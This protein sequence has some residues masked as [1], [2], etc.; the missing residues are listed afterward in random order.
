[1]RYS[2]KLIFL[3]A[4]LIIAAI[5]VYNFSA[6]TSVSRIK[7]QGAD[8]ESATS[9][10]RYNILFILIETLR[11][12]HLG[13]YGYKRN[14]S[15]NM[16]KIAREGIFFTNFISVSPWT[17]PAVVSLFSGKYPQAVF[18]PFK[19]DWKKDY[20]FP[21][22][23]DTL[24]EILR[25]NG[26]HTIALSDHGLV[27]KELNYAQGFNVFEFLPP[28]RKSLKQARR[29]EVEFM[30]E[31]VA[32]QISECQ[33]EKFFLYL[34]VM[35][36]HYP[37][38]PPLKYRRKFGY[39]SG[40]EPRKISTRKLIR[41]Y[42]GE[43]KLTDDL[44]GSIYDRLDKMR[45]LEN[46]YLII[47]SDHG[48]GFREHG[49]I[50]HGTSLYR[51]LL[52]VPL[53]IHFPKTMAQNYRTVDNL[54]SFID[55]YP[56]IMEFA[57]VS[58]FPTVDGKSLSRFIEKKEDRKFYSTIFSESPHAL[59]SEGLSCQNDQFKLIFMPTD[60]S[61][62][63]EAR[64]SIGVKNVSFKRFQLYDLKNDIRE[65]KNILHGNEIVAFI[66]GLKLLWHK[67][68]NEMRRSRIKHHGEMSKE[69][70]KIVK[71]RFRSLGYL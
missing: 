16:D 71:D 17:T 20:R 68:W 65:Q 29:N 56:T 63:E 11:A 47:T 59:C 22:E 14:I 62:I 69:L 21:D 26:Y 36:P 23:V 44:I 54:T 10:K 31:K 3:L 35:Y 15:P 27:T 39:V 18:P 30:T 67:I 51:E 55:L 38:K 53:I 33:G 52:H 42:D 57:G 64:N 60:K 1:M 34:H 5:L 8:Q 45:L 12:D 46:T 61:S 37:Y 6:R 13:C 48:E 41:T 28:I 2:K 58:N 7:S 24:A 50:M 25:I 40:K 66:L 4:S 49:L 43:I 19:K 70:K 9:Q 32:E